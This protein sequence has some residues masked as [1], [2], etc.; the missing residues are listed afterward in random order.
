MSGYPYGPSGPQAVPPLPPM[1]PGPPAPPPAPADGLRAAAVG[2]LNLCGLGLGYAL[3][4]RWLAM[5]ACWVATAVLLL[6]ALPAEAD[7]VPGAALV[8]YAAFLVAAAVHGAL[9]GLRTPLTRPSRAPV[10]LLLGVV[11]LAV[12]AGGVVLYDRARDEAVE[13][14]LL[15]RLDEADRLVRAG[16]TQ[17][18]T[19]AESG[20]R[21]ALT[22]Y[23]DLDA[24]HPG[25]R[26]AGKV[27]DRLRA[28]YA[29]IG[30]PYERKDYCGAVAPLA[31]LRTVP[32]T[33]PAR[34]LG[35][36]A[37]WPDDRLA[38]SLYEC[39]ATALAGGD[40]TWVDRFADLLTAFSG[41]PQ[42][43]RVEPAVRA[44]VGRAEQDVRGTDPCAA[45]ERL[46][47]L[48][49]R[50]TDLSGRSSGGREALARDAGRASGSADAGAYPCGVDQ[51]RDG[52]FAGAQKTMEDFA[53]RHRGDRNRALAEKIAIAAEVAQTLPAAGKHLPTTAGGGSVSVTVKNDSP[54]DIRVLYT[55]P[56]T[57]SF[58]IKGCGNCTA[59]SW[60]STLN[61][62]FKPCDDSGKDYPQRTLQLPPGTT[63]FVHKPVGGTT[64]AGSD[65]AKLSSDYVYTECAYT[66]QSFGSTTS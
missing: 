40:A 47:G 7:G 38:T 57:G 4:R 9:A 34:S 6:V 3:L 53:A 13:K 42:A 37:A 32:R 25:S 56:V 48:G 29:T 49:A 52:D 54:D 36:L 61:P 1:P 14:M 12:P 43:A 65:T 16:G 63:W 45:V 58:T 60:S 5:A 35:A 64:T 28:Y 21:Q 44:A 22:S 23:R 20:Y 51:Y 11:L 27:P 19:A 59:Y 18:F 46:R 17:S 2:L 8:L 31:Y 39:G 50:I 33:M 62:A 10:A 66:T 55:G 24:N 41:S 15:D 30:A 26:A